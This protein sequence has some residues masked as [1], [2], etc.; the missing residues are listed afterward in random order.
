MKKDKRVKENYEFTRIINRKKFVKTSSFI[1][2]YAPKA[3]EK[4]RL[5]ISVGKKLGNAVT[6]NKIKRQIRAMV[7]EVFDFTED[8]DAVL[9][10][11]PNFSKRS[12]EELKEELIYSRK[13][14]IQQTRGTK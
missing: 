2:Y 9:I 5:G 10:A 13:K 1:L 3:R 6:R 4:N 14:A 12:F 8:F 7:D 11:R